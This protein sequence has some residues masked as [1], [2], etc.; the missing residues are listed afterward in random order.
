MKAKS[1]KSI[2][3]GW[4]FIKIAKKLLTNKANLY[5][6]PLTNLDVPA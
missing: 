2:L 3:M 4:F 5:I 1:P 6:I